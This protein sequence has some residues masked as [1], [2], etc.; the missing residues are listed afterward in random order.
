MMKRQLAKWGL[1]LPILGVCAGLRS[2]ELP[3]ATAHTTA[4]GCPTTRRANSSQTT[5]ER[6]KTR[7]TA[8]SPPAGFAH[9]PNF[10]PAEVG[11]VI[12]VQKQPAL[13][14]HLLPTLQFK[15]ISLG[16][17][18]SRLADRTGTNLAAG[19]SALRAAGVNTRAKKTFTLPAQSYRLDIV[20]VLKIFAPRVRMVVTASENVIF[21]TTEAQDDTHLVMRRY[22]LADLVAN[23]PR[24]IRPGA[25]RQAARVRKSR[26]AATR[27]AAYRTN[28]VNLITDNVRPKVWLN[29]GG[30]AT[31]TQIGDKVIVVA[32]ASVQALLQ[33]P[34]HYNPNR[35]PLYIIF[36]Y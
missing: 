14:A 29:H 36:S 31:I 7:T 22:W 12:F 3:A 4:S 8:V 18:L 5:H 13:L 1:I 25:N 19:W 15:H 9:N 10:R 24:I 21:L 17:S 34:S 20:D 32:P 26:G 2:R 23:L 33:G 35:I 28:I 27:P 30:K 11:C 6:V 16:G